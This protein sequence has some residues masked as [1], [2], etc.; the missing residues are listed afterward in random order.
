MKIADFGLVRY[1]EQPLSLNSLS[2]TRSEGSNTYGPPPDN[3]GNTEYD[4]FSLGTMI[5]EIACFDIGK[6]SRLEGYQ[7][8]REQDQLDGERYFFYRGTGSLNQSVIQ[9]HREL[10]RLA[11]QSAHWAGGPGK[12]RDWQ[13][14]FYRQPFFDL[15]GS[16][17]QRADSRRPTAEDLANDLE[18]PCCQAT[19]AEEQDNL[20]LVQ[21]NEELGRIVP[22][23][24][25][26]PPRLSCESFKRDQ[27][28]ETQREPTTTNATQQDC[29][30]RGHTL[31]A[32]PSS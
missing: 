10:L 18:K 26:R 8:N 1:V 24:P 4:I 14:H 25:L 7:R 21:W 32:L 20:E 31:S 29:T 16:M 5:S 27:R 15:I 19:E 22:E 9:E 17:L 6:R 30:L 12:L 23:M 13:E 11:G 2:S 28:P 3:D